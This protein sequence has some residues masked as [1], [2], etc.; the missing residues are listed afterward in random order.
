[1]SDDEDFFNFG[2]YAA[3]SE[4]ESAVTTEAQSS[5]ES[6]KTLQSEKDKTPRKLRLLRGKRATASE[7]TLTPEEKPETP[8]S[9]EPSP[10]KAISSIRQVPSK[11]R[12]KVDWSGGRPKRTAQQKMLGLVRDIA[13]VVVATLILVFALNTWVVRLYTIPSGSMETTLNIGDHVAVNVAYPA[14]GG[15]HRGDIIVFKDP[16]GWL[17][18]SA[19]GGNLVK[20][21]IGLPGETVSCC[22]VAGNV[23]ING[24]TLQE[25]Y[26]ASGNVPSNINFKVKVPKGMLFVM[27][28]NRD[29]S[30]DSRYHKN[31]KPYSYFVPIKDVIGQA[32]AIT[33]PTSRWSFLSS[34]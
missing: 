15:I 13:I 14:I 29:N 17:T 23:Q 6:P 3:S 32:V 19:A 34:K 5:S 1:M 21:V 31:A 25:N 2:S 12:T 10:A 11:D 7:T 30:F 8:T 33:W 28:D 24:K 26:V 18:G 9:P 22:D 4:D 16:G 27:G 20:R